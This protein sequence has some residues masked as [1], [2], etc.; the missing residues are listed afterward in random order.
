[1]GE[2]TGRVPACVGSAQDATDGID[3]PAAPSL[4]AV[5]LPWLDLA[6]SS[7]VEQAGAQCDFAG[8]AG[9]WLVTSD[10]WCLSCVLPC[11]LSCPVR[12]S[13]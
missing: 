5:A 3:V 10:C 13:H 7:W 2:D 6:G 11:V 4:G 9:D 12:S 8:R 1:M